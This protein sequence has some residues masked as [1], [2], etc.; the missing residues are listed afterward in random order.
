MT[1][2]SLSSSTFSNVLPKNRASITVTFLNMCNSHLFILNNFNQSD[3]Q[4][5]SFNTSSH[6]LST[7]SY[8]KLPQITLCHLQPLATDYVDPDLYH[9]Y[10]LQIEEDCTEPWG[11]PLQISAQ[12]DARLFNISAFYIWPNPQ[13]NLK[14]YLQC[15]DFN[16]NNNLTTTLFENQDKLYQLATPHQPHL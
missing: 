4:L 9:L 3:D 5:H 14:L 12:S 16:F 2:K 11:T 7:P 13:S 1:P 8:Y 15:H 10:K 6:I